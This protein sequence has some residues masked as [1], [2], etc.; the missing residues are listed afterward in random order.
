MVA[1]T[2]MEAPAIASKLLPGLG[3]ILVILVSS[4]GLIFNIGNIG[5]CGL[6][7][8]T[9]F[10]TDVKTGAVASGIIAMMIFMNAEFG[11]KMDAFTKLLGFVMIALVLFTAIKSHP[12]IADIIHHTF[13]PKQFN[14]NA[15]ITI[16]GGT[17]GGYISFAGAHRMLDASKGQG[18]ALQ[19]TDRAAMQGILLASLMRVLLFIA[20]AGVVAT[21]IVLSKANPAADVF[22]ASAG[23]VGLKLQV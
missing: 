18:P 1:V 2:Q 20:A 19:N 13:I 5:G 11:R 12:P 6:G 7:T 17:V 14:F 23:I 15:L 4:G 9:L 22:N 8:Q 16:V 21:G 3:F 10:G